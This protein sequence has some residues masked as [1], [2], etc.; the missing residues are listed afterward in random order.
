MCGDSVFWV[1]FG[2]GLCEVLIEYFLG[3]NRKEKKREKKKRKKKKRKEK[4]KLWV[5]FF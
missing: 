2:F 4:D 1:W 5:N 3:D